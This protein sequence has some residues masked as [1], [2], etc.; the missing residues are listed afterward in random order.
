MFTL[1][2]SERKMDRGYRFYLRTVFS[3]NHW[4]DK[5]KIPRIL[6]EYLLLYQNINFSLPHTLQHLYNQRPGFNVFWVRARGLLLNS[7]FCIFFSFVPCRQ[8]KMHTT[9]NLNFESILSYFHMLILQFK[10]GLVIT[11]YLIASYMLLG[12]TFA[13]RRRLP[14]GRIRFNS[15]GNRFCSTHYT[16]VI[17]RTL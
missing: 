6:I 15:S 17:R 10:F 7:C 5:F 9:Y 16:F 8:L 11:F 2:R 3:N 1:T 4:Y 12:D 13:P 14:L